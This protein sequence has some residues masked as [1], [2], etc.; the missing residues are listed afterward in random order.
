MGPAAGTGPQAPQGRHRQRRCNAPRSWHSRP[1]LLKASDGLEREKRVVEKPR[2]APRKGHQKAGEE[3][4]TLKKKGVRTPVRPIG[5]HAPRRPATRPMHPH[6]GA[7][8]EGTSRTICS[9][10]QSARLAKAVMSKQTRALRSTNKTGPEPPA[11][12]WHVKTARA[13]KQGAGPEYHS[14]AE[15]EQRKNNDF[16]SHREPRGTR[17]EPFSPA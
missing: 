8:A 14:L 5:R 12:A 13:R 6:P 17:R 7:Q 15:H 11:R 2:E 10:L 3:T 9:S 4:R 1:R 16:G